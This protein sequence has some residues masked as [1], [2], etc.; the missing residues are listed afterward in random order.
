[1]RR[2]NVAVTH[3]TNARPRSVDKGI[4]T[5]GEAL[6]S[7]AALASSTHPASMPARGLPD[8]TPLSTDRG[9]RSLLLGKSGSLAAL[10]G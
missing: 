1:M 6:I 5:R 10:A 2:V 9:S 4:E 7:R 3:V 8:F